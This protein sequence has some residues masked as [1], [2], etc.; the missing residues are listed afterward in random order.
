MFCRCFDTISGV[1][2]LFFRSVGLLR[3]AWAWLGWRTNEHIADT[4]RLQFCRRVKEEK[5][6]RPNEFATGKMFGF[7]KLLIPTE[8]DEKIVGSGC[9]DRCFPVYGFQSFVSNLLFVVHVRM[10]FVVDPLFSVFS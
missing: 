5:A 9:F 1:A 10:Q 4:P 7:E 6:S 3:S 8:S 2:G